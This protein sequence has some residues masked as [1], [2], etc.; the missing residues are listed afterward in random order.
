M[1]CG[2]FNNDVAFLRGWY[3]DSSGP[4]QS[5][6]SGRWALHGAVN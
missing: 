1:N 5:V 2:G 3:G 4:L 6:E